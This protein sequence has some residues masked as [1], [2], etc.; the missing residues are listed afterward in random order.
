MCTR[1]SHL[2][3]VVRKQYFASEFILLK[4]LEQ[5][6]LRLLTLLRYTHRSLINLIWVNE[7]I[8]KV[9]SVFHTF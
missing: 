8:V 6:F 4:V 1:Q 2:L 5:I 9:P 7:P 3:E